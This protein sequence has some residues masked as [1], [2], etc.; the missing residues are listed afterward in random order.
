MNA[1]F[2]RY[3]ETEIQVTAPGTGLKSSG[4]VW[5]STGPDPVTGNLLW[6]INKVQKGTIEKY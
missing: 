3:K 5:A 4:R 2:I 1:V 6:G